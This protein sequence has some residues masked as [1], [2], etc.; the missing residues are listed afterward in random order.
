[1][2]GVFVMPEY[3]R[4]DY[5]TVLTILADTPAGS[6]DDEGE[7]FSMAV[8]VR[9]AGVDVHESDIVIVPLSAPI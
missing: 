8:A 2:S 6:S 7:Y 5:M 1:M 9:K 3:I 4:C